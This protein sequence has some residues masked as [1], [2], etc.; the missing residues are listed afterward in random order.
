MLYRKPVRGLIF[1]VLSGIAAAQIISKTTNVGPQVSI[2]AEGS[3]ETT[4]RLWQIGSDLRYR[5]PLESP[6]GSVSVLDLKAPAKA[7][8]EYDKGYQLLQRKD[9]PGAVSHLTVATSIYPS[10]VAAHSALGSAYL[11]LGKS[12]EA[13]AEFAQT[14]SLDGHLPSSYLNLACAQMALKHYSE[15][16]QSIRQASTLAPL[17]LQLL[18]ALAYGEFM[19]HNYQAAVATVQQLHGQKHTGFAKAHL[20]A[21]AAWQAQNNFQRA[22]DELEIFL[23][24]DPHSALSGRVRETMQ[25]LKEAENHPPV[26]PSASASSGLNISYAAM[27]SEGPSG[28]AQLPETFRKLMQ[29]SKENK[30]IAEA[31]AEAACPNCEAMGPPAKTLTGVGQ[32]PSLRPDYPANNGGYTLRASADEVAV[33]FTATDHGKAVSN[34]AARD[35]GIR[36]DRKAPTA[37]TGFRNE[38][39]LPLRLAIVIDTS[40]SIADRFRFEQESAT[41]FL[42]SV[43]TGRNDL[44]F[45][46]GVSNSVLLVQDFTGD[47]N[48][49]TRAVGQMA[50]SG[51]TALWDAVAFAAEKLAKRPEPYPVARMIVVISDGEDNSSNASLKQA[52]NLAQRG[53]VSVCTVSTLEAGDGPSSDRVGQHALKTLA[54]LTGGAAFDP[55]SVHR[56]THSFSDLQ[57]VI[58]SRY[59]IS[60]KPAQFKRDGRY[61]TIEIAA[62]KDGHKLH[63]YTRKGYFAAEN[64]SGGESF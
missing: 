42:R 6:G 56:L 18:T 9:L 27:P 39:D 22:Q 2:G 8:R 32:G 10:F 23:R 11:G 20:Y 28:L 4:Y 62:Q 34:L 36:D 5:S 37:I 35:I 3:D 50:A 24:E 63:V 57:Q 25:Q 12:E 33:F 19:N 53:E 16:E 15:A 58:R 48:L 64:S 30:Q 47:Q 7:R 38:S 29:E 41:D 1:F 45:V 44:A 55:G 54:E 31:E 13:Q 46:V 59:L 61:R 21:S 14:V 51:G 43:V 49:L 52:I 17:D 40:A 26:T 60:Y